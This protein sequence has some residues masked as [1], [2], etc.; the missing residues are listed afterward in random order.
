MQIRAVIARRDHPR[1]QA[2]AQAAPPILRSSRDA[3]KPIF[4]TLQHKVPATH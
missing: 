2:L 4:Y 1:E 3:P